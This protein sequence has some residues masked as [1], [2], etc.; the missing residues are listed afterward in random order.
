MLTLLIIAELQL[1]EAEVYKL[2]FREGLTVKLK[3]K[4]ISVKLKS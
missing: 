4:N 3:H 1:L 2:E